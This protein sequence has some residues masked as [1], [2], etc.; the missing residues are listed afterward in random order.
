[1]ENLSSPIFFL[2][3]RRVYNLMDKAVGVPGNPVVT[4]L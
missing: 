3:S 1:M 4:L 2:T